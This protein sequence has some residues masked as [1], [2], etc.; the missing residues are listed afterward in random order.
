M[1]LYAFLAN[2][3][4]SIHLK[5]LLIT[6]ITLCFLSLSYIPLTPL[7]GAVLEFGVGREEITVR[8]LCVVRV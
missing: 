3:F 6:C 7:R 4:Y 8:V 2:D 1:T 5:I